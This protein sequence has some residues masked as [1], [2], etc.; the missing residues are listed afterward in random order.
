MN[1]T[2]LLYLLLFVRFI[3]LPD[4]YLILLAVALRWT[5]VE[6]KHT[7]FLRDF[8]SF[9]FSKNKFTNYAWQELLNC[10]FCNGTWAGYV[11]FMIF[12]MQWTGVSW[13]L[14]EFWLFSITCGL[15]SL[16]LQ[17]KMEQLLANYTKH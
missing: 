17:L 5:L 9:I 2:N 16:F 11:I 12:K 6:Y 14:L 15:F 10:P 3:L 7:E 13:Q 1:L 8:L 4:F